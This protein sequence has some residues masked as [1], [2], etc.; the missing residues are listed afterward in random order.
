MAYIQASS[1]DVLFVMQIVGDGHTRVY[2]TILHV[3]FRFHL[4][5]V[6]IEEEV[7]S[8]LS[9]V[10]RSILQLSFWDNEGQHWLFLLGRYKAFGLN[11]ALWSHPLTSNLNLFICLVSNLHSSIL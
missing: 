2:A 10:D 6:Y 3:S 5:L 11:A 4:T 8:K 7:L 9:K 1:H